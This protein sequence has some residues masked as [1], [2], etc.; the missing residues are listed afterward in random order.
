M[1]DGRVD[2]HVAFPVLKRSSPPVP[3]PSSLARS[4]TNQMGLSAYQRAIGKSVGNTGRVEERGSQPGPIPR[5]FASRFGR[6]KC[7]RRGD[8]K[9]L[10]AHLSRGGV[11]GV[12]AGTSLARRITRV[13]FSRNRDSLR[14]ALRHSTNARTVRLMDLES[15]IFRFFISF[16][17]WKPQSYI[18]K[19]N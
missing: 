16:K 4:G 15:R 11:R 9:S 18:Y 2:V 3:E 8:S 1:P 14:V 13:I 19:T 7:I 5:L 17:L 6:K 10:A 12:R